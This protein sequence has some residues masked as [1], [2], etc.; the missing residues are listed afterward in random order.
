MNK[1]TERLYSWQL[2]TREEE[3]TLEEIALCRLA[4]RRFVTNISAF[5]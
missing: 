5:A 4:I 2:Y 3:G 1:L